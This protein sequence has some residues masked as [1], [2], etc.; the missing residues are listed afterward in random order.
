MPLTKKMVW[1][2]A[3]AV[4]A[5][6]ALTVAVPVGSAYAIDEVRCLDDAAGYLVVEGRS[7]LGGSV[8]DCFANAGTYNYVPSMWATRI[9]TGNNAVVVYDVNGT[10]FSLNKWTVYKP[11]NA[12][13]VD[14]IEIR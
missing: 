1:S 14:A 12:T 3:M 9:A 10:K 8:K 5:A 2:S 6:A 7:E 13:H 11:T 4:A